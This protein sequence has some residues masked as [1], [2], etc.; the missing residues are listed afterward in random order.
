MKYLDKRMGLFA[1]LLVVGCSGPMG[2]I[3]GGML[4]GDQGTLSSDWSFAE[5]A[6]HVQLE[7]LDTEG[8][9]HSVNIWA[10]VVDGRLFVPTCWCGVQRS[11][12]REPGFAM[13]RPTQ[14]C[15]SGLTDCCIRA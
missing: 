9:P 7:T 14:W 15:G 2:P 12:A 11:R 10:G 5:T 8:K 6:D 3:P 1:V 4:K 13:R